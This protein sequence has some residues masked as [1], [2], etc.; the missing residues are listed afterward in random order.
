MNK[1]KELR[2]EIMGLELAKYDHL[3][4]VEKIDG[5]IERKYSEMKTLTKL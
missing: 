5:M 4:K 3:K 1:L 2:I